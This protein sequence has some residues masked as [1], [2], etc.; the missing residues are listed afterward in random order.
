M[1]EAHVEAAAVAVILS[2]AALIDLLVAPVA[3]I[4]VLAALDLLANR[5]L[6][7]ALVGCREVTARAEETRA[8]KRCCC[9]LLLS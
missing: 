2:V 5:C 4:I 7:S 1:A 8:N 9:L 6:L 3:A